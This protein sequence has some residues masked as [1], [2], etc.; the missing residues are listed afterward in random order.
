VT[1]F[2]KTLTLSSQ[3]DS[4]NLSFWNVGSNFLQKLAN[5]DIYRTNAT[6]LNPT[7]VSIIDMLDADFCSILQKSPTIVLIQNQV[8]FSFI[9]SM[10][11]LPVFEKN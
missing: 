10:Q 3:K 6:I 2:E 4:L 11:Y 1:I 9:S 8:G 5:I 7:W